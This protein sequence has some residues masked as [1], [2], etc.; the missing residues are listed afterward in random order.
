MRGLGDLDATV[1]LRLA[2]IRTP[3]PTAVALATPM[4]G[5]RCR[6]PIA[7]TI[8]PGVMDSGAYGLAEIRES[9]G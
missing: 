1:A 8:A 2:M 6:I 3:V 4:Y 7:A 9:R 5:T